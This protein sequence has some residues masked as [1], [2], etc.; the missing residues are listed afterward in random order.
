[1]CSAGASLGFYWTIASQNSTAAT[2]LFISFACPHSQGIGLIFTWG[3]KGRQNMEP[4]SLAPPGACGYSGEATSCTFH[5]KKKKKRHWHGN[6]MQQ[7]NC[8]PSRSGLLQKK[9]TIN[10]TSASSG[11]QHTLEASIHSKLKA[12][13][14]LSGARVLTQTLVHTEKAQLDATM[15]STSLVMPGASD[16]SCFEQTPMLVRDPRWQSLGKIREQE[17]CTSGLLGP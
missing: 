15:Q 16:Y 1:M 12:R 3:A 13:V 5:L 11:I 17:E 6:F 2:S 14:Q 4:H 7:T 8:S 9:P 10:Q